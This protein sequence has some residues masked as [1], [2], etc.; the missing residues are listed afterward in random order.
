[1]AKILYEIDT[2][3]LFNNTTVAQDK[4]VLK[5]FLSKMTDDMLVEEVVNRELLSEVFGESRESEQQ[6]I[7]DE[8]ADVFGYA[9]LEE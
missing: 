9:K 8:W 4:E 3:D 2:D 1:M 6:S 5:E 7:I